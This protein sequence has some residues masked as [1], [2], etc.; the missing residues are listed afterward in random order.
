MNLKYKII[1]FVSLA[2]SVISI[3]ILLFS[4]QLPLDPDALAVITGVLALF[5]TILIG[6]QIFTIISIDDKINNSVKKL[7]TEVQVEMTKIKHDAIGISTIMQASTSLYTNNYREAFRGC[8]NGLSCLYSGTLSDGLSKDSI[9]KC[10]EFLNTIVDKENVWM[11][12]SPE[13]KD[14]YMRTLYRVKDDR[15][16]KII[17]FV[18]KARETPSEIPPAYKGLHTFNI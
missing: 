4:L 16:K 17:D 15:A 12:L 2:L 18:A 8:I 3:T 6:W 10:F 7:T 5:V 11:V 14:S 13:D 1:L 9:N